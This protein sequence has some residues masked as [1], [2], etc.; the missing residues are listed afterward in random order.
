MAIIARDNIEVDKLL[1]LKSQA[2]LPTYEDEIEGE[3]VDE[4]RNRE[5][6]NESR[7]VDFENECKAI[8]R[9]GALVDIISWDEA[10]TKAKSL[11]YSSLLNEERRTYHQKNPHTQIEKCTT[12]E[13]V[14]ELNITFTIPRNTTFDRLIFSNQCDNHMNHSRHSIVDYVKQ[15]NCARSKIWKRI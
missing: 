7:I 11:I 5:K 12:H 8:E 14:H 9:K 1:K 2:A 15:A 10:D 4:A 6:R 13:L 3:T